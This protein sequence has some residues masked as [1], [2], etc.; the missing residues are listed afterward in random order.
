[1]QKK[2]YGGVLF[3][4]VNHLFM[5][6]VIIVMLYPFWNTVALSLNDAMDSIRGDIYLWPRVFTTFNYINLFATGT[7]INAFY[8]SV[9]RTVLTTAGNVFLSA[10]L[11]YILSQKN[12]VLHRF[13]TIFL[14]LTMY[15][16]AGL[17]PVYF[18]F[19]G[20]GLLNNFWV[21][22]LPNLLGAF[23]VIVIRTYMK[24]LPPSLSESAKIDGAG[25][26]RIFIQIVMPLCKPVLA[27]IALWVAVGSWNSWFDTFIFAS[28]RQELST[29][30]FEMMKLLSS[31]MVQSAGVNAQQLAQ[32][33][34]EGAASNTVT[35]MSIRSAIT[36]VAALPILFTYPFLQKYF[37]AGLHLGS[38]K[39]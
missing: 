7:L 33:A 34:R 24:T 36:V 15:V 19:R 37:V 11:A 17:I 18:L 31:S 25:D 1:M 2:S 32:S 16:S 39:E 20:L 28:A 6:I 22:V 13:M 5:V 29:L 21:Y 9:A 4:G 8:V 3:D 14:I 27:C 23:N 26:F 30:Q 35:P 38:V 10:M 12:F